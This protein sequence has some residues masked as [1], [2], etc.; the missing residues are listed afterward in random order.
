MASIECF[1]SFER[2]CDC[3]VRVKLKSADG[4]PVFQK[5]GF[6]VRSGK[7]E[8]LLP[9]APDFYSIYDSDI[10]AWLNI[11]SNWC[12][13]GDSWRDGEKYLRCDK[14]NI[15]N[16]DKSFYKK[17]PTPAPEGKKCLKRY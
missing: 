11:E 17:V 9:G 1:C 5:F 14:S 7:E 8:R 12:V 2:L 3:Y 6:V 15:F 10:N 16:F 4:N 13:D